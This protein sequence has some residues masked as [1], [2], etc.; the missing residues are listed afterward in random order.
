MKLVVN[1]SPLIFLGKVDSLS[2]LQATFS[3]ILM[4]PAVEDEIRGL[5]L[6]PF[7]QRTALS[8]EGRAYVRGALGRLHAGELEAM[9]LAQELQ[10]DFVALDDLLARRKAHRLGLVPVGTVGLLLLANQRGLL[11]AARVREKLQDLIDRHGLY[12]SSPVLERVREALE[13]L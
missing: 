8:P 6:P 11:D 5:A 13:D 4:P 1:A 12:L 10:A 3:E 2:L 7:I 9:V